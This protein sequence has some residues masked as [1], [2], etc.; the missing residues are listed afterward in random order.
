MALAILQKT[1]QWFKGAWRYALAHK[2]IS[3]VALVA[4]LGAS[5]WGVAA[6]TGGKVETR[7][8]LGVVTRGTI[9]ST[10]SASGQVSSSR[11]LDIKPE[12]SGT[13]TYLPV[14]AGQQVK[15][16]QLIA[17]IDSTD[18]Q[19][20]LRDAQTSLET[21]QLTLQKLQ[22]PATGLTLAQ[23][24]NAVSSAQDSLDKTYVNS[25]GD[26]TD[27]FLDMPDIMTHLQD[28]I[29]G[30]TA[31]HGSQWNIDFYLNSAAQY[32]DK[33]R[34]Y[35]DD[36]YNAYVAAKAAYD[37][38]F[39][40]YKLMGNS[41]SD[42]TIES[43]TSETNDMVKAVSN[44][45]KNTNAFIQLYTN[46]LTNHNLTP[47]TVATA[48]LT[49]LAS[50]IQNINGKLSSLT[51]DV[52]S[53]KSGKQ[54][55][56]EK[57][58][59]LQ[60]LTDGA[61]PLDVRGDELS[62]QQKQDA[63]TDA[64]TTLAKYSVRAPFDGTITAVN[65]YVGDQGGSAAL[66]TLVTPQQIAK[67]SLNEVDAAKV[68]VGNKATLTFDAID[69][70]TLTGTVAQ[71]DVAGTVSQGVVSYSVEIAFDTQDTR[72]KPGMTVNAA[73]Q[74]DTKQDVLEVP[75]SAVKTTNGTSYVQAFTPALA[76]TGGAQGV[77]SATPPGMIEVTT[78]LSDDTN[79]EIV[80][81]L[82][83]GQQI[84]PRTT[85]TGSKTTTASSASRAGATGGNATF[86]A[87]GA[88]GFGGSA[89][90]IGG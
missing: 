90:R 63:V 71:V 16:G 87:T 67:L 22:A 5:W 66:A 31:S 4:V 57:Q 76:E 49:T 34:A 74:T 23:S 53:V 24:Q 83:E 3:A 8:T 88:A 20:A 89:V 54:S 21:A 36:A 75:S 29:I 84:V 70:L 6:A 38:A 41:P 1:K 32:D 60:D 82:S 51:S 33:A 12:V 59:S 81:G 85:T 13:I 9:V 7:Y 43:M 17:S 44:A 58:L 30:T 2:V 19:K 18:A 40:D 72:V 50:D 37:K 42:A 56:I 39:A 69:S 68:K 28:E 64:Y 14:K 77:T 48:A 35:R 73:I 86:R 10:V 62:V 65:Q 45:L 26:V 11:S 80:S 46:S 78:G 15:K 27:T 25:E 55:L 79:V 52:S 47:S 61:D